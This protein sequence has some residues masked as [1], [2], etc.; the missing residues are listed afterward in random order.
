MKDDSDIIEEETCLTEFE[1]YISVYTENLYYGCFYVQNCQ[2][3]C[4]FQ[5]N[6]L[7]AKRILPTLLNISTSKH[8]TK[9]KFL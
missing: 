9:R 8:I 7:T 3:R 2:I 4:T 6:E 5:V 1:Y